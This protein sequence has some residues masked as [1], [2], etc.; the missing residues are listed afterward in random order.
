MEIAGKTHLATIAGLIIPADALSQPR[1]RR[2][3]PGRYVHSTGVD[4]PFRRLDRIDLI[5]PDTS[6]SAGFLENIQSQLPASAILQP[7]EA[8]SG[9]VAQMTTAFRV[10]LTALS[11]LALVV[12]LFLIYNTITFSVVQRRT[13]F[14]VLRSLGVTREEV[15]LLVLS[16][17]FVVGLLGAIFG[18]GLGIILGQGTVRL[19][20]QTI[21]D[22]FFVVT[23]RGIQ[24]PL[25]SLVKGISLG[26][27]ATILAAAP[28]AWE[29]A[30]APPRLA[31]SRSGL[32]S[33]AQHAVGLA[34]WWGLA[35]IATGDWVVMAAIKFPGD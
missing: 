7:V 21:N 34:A 32:E 1:L 28:P 14:G 18:A 6:A 16:E 27:I 33:K 12:G 25:S 29:A 17:A 8:R 15:F 13:L 24:I 20:T 2:T 31:L 5:I 30:S 35:F 22:L 11:M 3:Y 4:R 9:A 10:N 26:V 19:V 23:V